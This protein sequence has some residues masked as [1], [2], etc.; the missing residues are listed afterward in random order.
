M[1]GFYA[2][3]INPYLTNGPGYPLVIAFLLK[4][5]FSLIAIKKLNLLYLFAS[6]SIFYNTSK[7]LIQNEKASLFFAL[8]FEYYIITCNAEYFKLLTEP[9]TIL[10]ICSIT[11]LI[12]LNANK[13]KLSIGVLIGFLILL[14][15]IFAY[16]VISLI[17]IFVI[18]KL[19]DYKIKTTVVFIKILLLASVVS[20]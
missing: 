20:R 18:K 17:A 16:V 15:V 11:Y 13:Y 14:K 5:N 8:L 19:M 10:L 7:L 2:D 6:I 9:L 4:L 3:P 12:L 1:N